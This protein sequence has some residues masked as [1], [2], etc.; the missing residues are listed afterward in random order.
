METAELK[1]RVDILDVVG[2]YTD[3]TRRGKEYVGLCPLH[4]EKTPSFTVDHDNGVYYCF[5]CG[6]GG[7]VIKFVMEAEGLTFR[8]AMQR[9]DDPG[10]TAPTP[11]P[12]KPKKAKAPPPDH[13]QYIRSCRARYKDSAGAKYMRERGFPDGVAEWCGVGYDPSFVYYRKADGAKLAGKFVIFPTDNGGYMA[14]NIDI[15]APKEDLKRNAP[16]YSVGPF[17]VFW[18]WNLPEGMTDPF[19]IVEG[20]ADAMSFIASGYGAVGIGGTGN[21]NALL[22][23]LAYIK[24]QQRITAPFVIY[25]DGDEAGRKASAELSAGLTKLGIVHDVKEWASAEG[26]ENDKGR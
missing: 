23:D 10:K 14:R 16:G 25:M 11:K 18:W 20:A 15:N 7:D 8:D 1:Q 19:F 2:R 22:D 6:S 4:Q 12:S 9:L 3:L 24:K 13:E 26:G 21:V 5:G 17:P